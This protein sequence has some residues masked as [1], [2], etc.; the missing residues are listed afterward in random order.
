MV[1]KPVNAAMWDLRFRYWLYTVSWGI[2]RKQL[3]AKQF[4]N[5]PPAQY[6]H[7]IY[8]CS[9]NLFVIIVHALAI[10]K[11]YVSWSVKYIIPIPIPICRK[12]FCKM[13]Q[14]LDEA[15]AYPS[16]WYRIRSVAAFV[17]LKSK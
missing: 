4:P 11:L 6:N 3:S 15:L 10:I 7:Y 13:S 17:S 12:L 2:A 5:W 9:Q 16:M 14:T 8:I 1:P